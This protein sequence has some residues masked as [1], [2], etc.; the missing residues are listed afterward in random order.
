MMRYL[1]FVAASLFAWQASATEV[2]EVVTPKGFKAW[3][4][5]E[6]ALPL[7][8]AKVA[9]NNAGFAYDEKGKEGR[10]GM[11]AAL[12]MEGAGD[13]DSH[14]FNEA[15]ENDAIELNFATD[16]DTLRASLESLSEHK[17]KAFSYLGLALT[18]PRFDNGAVERVR[19]Q[20]LSILTQ[21]ERQPGYLLGRK[22]QQV[23]FGNHPYGQ[24]V[25]GTKESIAKLATADFTSFTQHYVTRENII[26]AVVGDI[27]PQELSDLLDKNLSGLPEKYTPAMKLAPVTL[28][29]QAKQE[30]VDL[31]VP[32]TMV[33]FGENGLKRDDP[34]YY[35]AYVMNHILGGGGSLSAKLAEEIREKR[36][37]AYSVYSSLDPMTE[38]AVWRGGFATRN[39]QVGTALEVLRNTLKDF[40]AKGPTDK[41]MS[42]AKKYLTGSFVLNLG[43]N[44][45]IASYLIS[46]QIN[47]LGRDYLDKRNGLMNA[48]KKEDV[49]AIAARLVD[50]SKLLV[51]MVG[52]PNLKVEEKKP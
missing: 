48:V 17:D 50:P 15:L 46:M 52:K 31:D 40:A 34:Q 41:E 32:Q 7:I 20:T 3:L 6:H 9:F 4:V 43:S 2:K 28:P 13:M 25:L 37:L 47:H 33:V 35:A 30:V 26:I 24:P 22:W 21:Q 49:K 44:G 8:A 36:G 51:V 1:V 18:K 11:V 16:E 14:A 39:D 29:T 38:G 42:D 27:T 12:L 23:A 19:S 10:A 5:E 45:E